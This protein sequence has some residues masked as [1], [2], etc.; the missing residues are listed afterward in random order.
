MGLAY[1][2]C[3]DAKARSAARVTVVVGPTGLV[4]QAYPKVD[5]RSHPQ[6]VLE[7][8]EKASA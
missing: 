8:L 4:E 1:G 6:T 7:A 3:E 2:A 5:A